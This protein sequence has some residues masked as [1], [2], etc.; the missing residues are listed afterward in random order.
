M[1]ALR[2]PR[3]TGAAAESQ[4]DGSALL[5][6]SCMLWLC[7]VLVGRLPLKLFVLP[8][9]SAWRAF[10]SAPML[11]VVCTDRL[12]VGVILYLGLGAA[13]EY[14]RNDARGIDMIPNLEFWKDFPFL[15][16][17]GCVYFV[18][19][20]TCGKVCGGYSEI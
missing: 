12:V 20:V 19:L 5:S 10:H 8:F 11:T 13:W 15:F 4:L 6:S 1:V 9:I 18:R 17:D 2:H 3:A 7:G 14:K 16:W